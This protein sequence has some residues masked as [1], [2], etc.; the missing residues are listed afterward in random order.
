MTL[1]PAACRHSLGI[2]EVVALLRVSYAIH[3]ISAGN[4]IIDINTS[5]AIRPIYRVRVSEAAVSD[6]RDVSI[7]H[8]INFNE[9]SLG[10]F[11]KT[12][13]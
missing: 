10:A 13:P 7:S 8:H 4:T 1:A 5:S 11:W 6:I 3:K 12:P 2:K 9:Q